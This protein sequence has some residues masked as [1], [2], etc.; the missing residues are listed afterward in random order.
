[1]CHLPR[2]VAE[3]GGMVCQASG[4]YL[5]LVG[6]EMVSESKWKRGEERQTGT[7]QGG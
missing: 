7:L 6:F 2:R 3:C 1:M 5:L 4:F